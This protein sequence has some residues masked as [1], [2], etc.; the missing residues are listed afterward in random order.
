MELTQEQN[1]IIKN[2]IEKK[3]QELTVSKAISGTIKFVYYLTFG[4]FFNYKKHK[5]LLAVMKLI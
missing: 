2:E 4:Y 1:L 3:K 5:D